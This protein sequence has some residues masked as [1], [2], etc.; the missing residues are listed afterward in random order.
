MPNALS[1][2]RDAE[3]VP[4][5]APA[6]AARNR[7][8]IIERVYCDTR[9]TDV[10]NRSTP[11]MSTRRAALAAFVTTTVLAPAHAQAP[12]SYPAKTVRIVVPYAPGAGTDLHARAMAQRL[13]ERLGQ[14]I[15][16]DNRAGANGAIAMELVARSAPDGYTLVYALPA[17]YAVNPALYPKLAYDP[18]RDFEPIMLV[19]RAPLVL[20]AH[21]ALP[22]R[23][24]AELVKLA[25]SRPDSLVLASAGSGSAGHLAL[26]MFTMLSGTRILHVPYKGAAPSMVDLIAGQAQLSFLAWSTGGAHARTGRLRALGIT[27][28]KRASAL[29]D[30]PAIAETLKGFDIANWYGLAGPKGMPSAIVSKLHAETARVLTDPGL[31][32]SFEKEAIDIVGSTP[33]VFAEFLKSELAKWAMLV[34]ASGVSVD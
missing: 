17:Q 20:F 7:C 2:E 18:L 12:P 29:P 16:V 30:L 25:K 28:D 34:K 9:R 1:L 32:Q 19:A 10:P 8:A 22:V 31:R 6:L 24:I 13:T 23:S 21:P 4:A 14:Q 26:Q 15:V 33:E 11:A 5:A 27:A 3:A